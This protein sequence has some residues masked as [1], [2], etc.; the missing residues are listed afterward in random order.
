MIRPRSCAALLLP[1]GPSPRVL[2]WL[3]YEKNTVSWIAS[4]GPPQPDMRVAVASQCAL[5]IPS[6][7]AFGL[8]NSRYA[9][10]VLA[11]VPQASLIGDEGDLASCSAVFT[12]RRSRR[13]S[14]R[15]A[16]ANSC[17]THSTDSVPASIIACTSGS[18]QHAATA[19]TL[20]NPSACVQHFR[21]RH[22]NSAKVVRDVCNSKSL[23]T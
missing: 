22:Q 11:H 21:R 6:A 14:R 1:I 13:L 18:S 5:R 19:A 20:R 16:R 8:L 3:P 23:I 17:V 12:K 2:T 15:S 9:A 7:L 10:C 4:T